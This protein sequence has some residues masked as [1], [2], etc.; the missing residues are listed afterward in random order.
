MYQQ[1]AEMQA[2]KPINNTQLAI[3]HLIP[4]DFNNA[5]D[6][7]DSHNW[8]LFQSIA[9]NTS[10]PPVSPPSPPPPSGEKPI[11]VVDLDDPRATSRVRTACETWGVFQVTN[12]GVPAAVLDGIEHQ[13]RRFFASPGEKKLRALRS[14]EGPSGYGAA[15][16]SRFF[17]KMM[18]SEGLTIAG[19]PVE[20][21]RRVWPRDYSTFC[22]VIDD[23]KEEMKG[24][25]E[26]ICA[27]MFKSLGFDKRDVEWFEP[28]R[29]TQAIVQLNSYPKCPDPTRAMGLAPHT[30]S[31]L[32]TMLYH[33]NTSKGLQVQGPDMNWVDV[34]PIPN[35]I[36]VHVGDLMQMVSNG[37]F[38]SVLHR[39]IVSKA[40][41]RIS[42]AYSFGPRKDVK[43]SAPLG[44]MKS[45]DLPVYRPISWNEYLNIKSIYFNKA[46][47]HVLV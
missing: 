2:S 10:S 11:P 47:E 32:I 41:H 16:I 21:A 12:H 15:P 26:K 6:L 9:I 18:W 35:A 13:A 44:P 4:I 33:T 27:L 8:P 36:T 31:S 37:R 30:D 45:G 34:E 23:Y 22:T 17:S 38:K 1:P 3:D 28:K 25:A 7:P 19:S 20:H 5:T 39:A 42:V 46:M 29:L 40:H 14:P 43:V 24:L